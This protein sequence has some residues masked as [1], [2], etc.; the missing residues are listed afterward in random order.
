MAEDYLTP[1][2]RAT[3]RMMQQLTP[4]ERGTLMETVERRLKNQRPSPKKKTVK[5]TLRQKMAEA[6]SKGAA[7]SEAETRKKGRAVKKQ[8]TKAAKAAKKRA[9]K[10][11]KVAKKR[12][13]K[14][15]KG[16]KKAA[17]KAAVK[18]AEVAGKVGGAVKAVTPAPVAAAVSKA[19]PVGKVALKSAGRLAGPLGAAYSA[20]EAGKLIAS[21]DA[22]KEALENVEAMAEEGAATR[23]VTSAFDPINTI[24]GAGASALDLAGTAYGNYA[25]DTSETDAI[26]AD[27]VA[28]KA[29]QEEA[30]AEG[31]TP[32]EESR[33]RKYARQNKLKEFGAIQTGDQARSMYESVFGSDEVV[34]GLIEGEALGEALDK[35]IEM[36]AIPARIVKRSARKAKRAAR[37]AE[38]VTADDLDPDMRDM[39][40]TPEAE[41]APESAPESEVDYTDEAISLFK[42]THG[43]SFDPKSSMDKGKL[44]KMKAMLAKQGGL[45][46]MSPNQFALKVYRSS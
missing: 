9:T 35:G 11:A 19:A 29:A 24:Y 40:G 37:K 21:E 3:K 33:L 46:E 14:A 10:A 30:L 5:K 32:D 25:E 16:A 17:S 45:G 6:A 18:G 39:M 2:E 26:V 28:A 44:D 27:K 36:G 1:K 42:N 12:A 38:P 34:D 13:V 4:K 41:S 7:K 43:T 23:A 8:A 20:Y 22:R 15:T 31:L